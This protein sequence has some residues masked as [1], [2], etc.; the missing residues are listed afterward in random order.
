M[1]PFYP[2]HN[3]YYVLSNWFLTC[4]HGMKWSRKRIKSVQLCVRVEYEVL[5]QDAN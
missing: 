4:V 5:L 2:V 1:I 3:N